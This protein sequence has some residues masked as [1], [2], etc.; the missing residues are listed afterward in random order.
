MGGN[1]VKYVPDEFSADTYCSK[2][3]QCEGLSDI[4]NLSF[5]TVNLTSS[6]ILY[7]ESLE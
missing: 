1:H 7:T 4:D 3:I 5:S 6:P 2:K